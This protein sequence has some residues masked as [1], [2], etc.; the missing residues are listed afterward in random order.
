MPSLKQAIKFFGTAGLATSA[1][2]VKTVAQSLASGDLDTVT[3][4]S[5][6]FNTLPLGQLADASGGFIRLVRTEKP[7]LIGGSVSFQ[8]SAQ[9]EENLLQILL[10]GVLIAS[11]EQHPGADGQITVHTATPL[12]GIGGDVTMQAS[13]TNLVPE[14]RNIVRADLW[15]IQLG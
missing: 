1:K 10:D 3:F 14:A 4:D 9:P 15:V 11:A 12:L 8:G 6:A 2:L 5:V 7:V 13:Q